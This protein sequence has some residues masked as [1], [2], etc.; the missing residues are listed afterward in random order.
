MIQ[1]NNKTMKLLTFFINNPTS[2][3]S[4]KDIRKKTKISKATAVKWLK[5]L[6]K[7]NL[8]TFKKIGVTK[9][10]KLNNNSIIKQFK[11]LNRIISLEPL[12][13]LNLE[14]YLYGSCARGEE[15]EK[16]DIDILIISNIKRNQIVNK[17]DN[18][19]KKLGKVISFSIFNELE[20]GMMRKKDPAYYERVEKD[21]ILL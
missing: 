8:I 6:E 2:E 16:S 15:T 12:K 21:K 18:I 14:I 17:I 5:Y 13:K 4:Q 19:S 11:I 7:I 1:L 10:Y 3:T 20:W 9:L